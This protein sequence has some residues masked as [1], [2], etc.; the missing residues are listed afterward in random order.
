[1]PS[2]WKQYIHPLDKSKLSNTTQLDSVIIGGG[3]AG[4][5]LAYLL[6][7]NGH[8]VTLIEADKVLSG[9]TGHT[10]AHVVSLQGIYK[11]IHSNKKRKTYFDS[12]TDAIDGIE[13]II[14]EHKIDCDFRRVP[15]FVFAGEHDKT[16]LLKEYKVMRKFGAPVQYISNYKTPF[17][18]YDVISMENQAVFNPIKYCE[19]LINNSS[20]KIIENCRI[21]K[22]KLSAKKLKTEKQTFKYKRIIFATGFPIVNIRGLYAFKM[23]KSSSYA[24]CVPT[25]KKLDAVY[26]SM[27]TDKFTYRD[28]PDGII[29]GGMDHRT[30]RHKCTTYF[31]KLKEESRKFEENISHTWSANDSMTFDHVPYAG[32]MFRFL[33]KQTYVMTGFGKRGMTNSYACAQIVSDAIAK[34]KN[35]YRKAFKPTRILNIKVWTKLFWNFILDGLGLIAGGLSTR[36]RRCPHMGC[37]LK[38]NPNLKSYD[39]P[40]HG[41]RFTEKGD[42][43]VSP[44]VDANDTLMEAK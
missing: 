30:G 5:T 37:R 35:P 8:N 38:F 42:I 19:V 32:R 29:I 12:Q 43:I 31:D 7:Q 4:V 41:S 1:M 24:V 26:N 33:H 25:D 14:N 9:V 6:S 28:S 10:T 20:F 44:A 13:R 3:I 40:C 23:Y 34:K 39:C 17:G 16:D 27:T 36:K 2:V 18:I 11:D 22:V 15:G 21:K